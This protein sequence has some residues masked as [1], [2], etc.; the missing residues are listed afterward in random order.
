VVSRT[1]FES[2]LQIVQPFQQ[3]GDRLSTSIHVEV[4]CGKKAKLKI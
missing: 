3:K 1:L 2:L 4:H